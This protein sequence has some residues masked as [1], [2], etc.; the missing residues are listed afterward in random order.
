MGSGCGA[1]AL[2]VWT[3]YSLNNHQAAGVI[4]KSFTLGCIN[5]SYSMLPQ[6]VPIGNVSYEFYDPFEHKE[7]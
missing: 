2:G 5:H 4:N 1:E 3:M 7:D 6:V